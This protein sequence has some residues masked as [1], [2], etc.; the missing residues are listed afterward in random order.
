[1]IITLDWLQNITQTQEGCEEAFGLIQNTIPAR[2][3]LRKYFQTQAQA[4]EAQVLAL[5]QDKAEL[6]QELLQALRTTT[7]SRE[8]S[9]SVTAARKSTKLPD[10]PI[11]TGNSDPAIDDWLSKMKGKLKANSD[12]YPIPDLQKGYIENRVGGAAIK[13]LAPRLRPGTANPFQTAE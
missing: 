11:F 7:M 2:D 4:R 8:V 12:H 5:V 13:H 3:Q 9:P 6:S 1:V 10:P